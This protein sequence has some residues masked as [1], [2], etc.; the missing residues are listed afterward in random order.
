M[1]VVLRFGLCGRTISPRNS[2]SASV[3]DS[4]GETAQSYRDFMW[5]LE[6]GRLSVVLGVACSAWVFFGVARLKGGPTKRVQ[7][8]QQMW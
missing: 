2:S 8:K 4:A 3:S 7:R 1:T 6:R 5:E